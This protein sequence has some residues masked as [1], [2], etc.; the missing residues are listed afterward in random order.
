MTDDHAEG[1]NC[2]TENIKYTV[3]LFDLN[4]SAKDFWFWYE[5]IF[6]EENPNSNYFDFSVREEESGDEVL[7]VMQFNPEFPTDALVTLF[8][9]YQIEIVKTANQPPRVMN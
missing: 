6:K 5:N 2:L 7:E 1:C 8:M 4:K 3:T 9:G